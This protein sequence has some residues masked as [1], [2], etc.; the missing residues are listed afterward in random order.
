VAGAVGDLAWGGAGGDP[1]RDGGVSEVVRSERLEPGARDGGCRGASAPEF[2]AGI[3]AARCGEDELGP[4]GELGEVLLELVDDDAG[5][6]E[7]RRPARVLGGLM[8]SSPRT[9]GDR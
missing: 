7:A 3:A 2:G 8:M 5:E 6:G 1:E 9:V 4:R